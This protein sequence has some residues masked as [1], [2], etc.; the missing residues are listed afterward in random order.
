MDYVKGTFLKRPNR[1]IAEVEVDGNVEIAH[2]PNTGRCKELLVEGATV[3]L[4]PSDNPNR[5]TKYSLHFVENKSVLVSLFSQEANSIVYDAIIDGKIKE[6]SGYSYHKREKTVD[7][8]RIDI[9][10]ANNE[11]DCCGMNFLVDSCYIEVKGVTLIVDGEA[12]FPDAPTERGTKHL[13]ELI[14]LKKEGNRCV[15]FFLIQHPAG[16]FFRPN[17]D[18]DPEFSKTL[19]EA[20]DEGVEI[21]V[22]KCDN[23]LD[24]IELVPES[25]DFDLGESL[26]NGFIND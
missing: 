23:Q 7:N 25:L 8:S 3:W 14:K 20:Y 15:V 22:Y 10:L 9:Y 18:N 24:G 2:V 21:L 13:K 4:K 5:K 12:R 19:N 11:D 16:N 1:F 17:W 26:S 6:L